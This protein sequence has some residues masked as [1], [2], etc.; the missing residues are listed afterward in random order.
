MGFSKNA[1]RYSW[2]VLMLLTLASAACALSSPEALN[3]GKGTRKN[4]IPPQ[5]YAHTPDYDVRA[6]GVV[7]EQPE[8]SQPVDSQD[9]QHL[10]V[11]FQIRCD[12]PEDAICQI[13]EIR[14]GIQLVD[15]SG[16][17]YDPVF[18]ATIENLL[19][20]E[21]LGDGEKAGWLAFQVP[22]GVELV[23]AVAEYGD[24]QHVFFQLPSDGGNR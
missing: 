13:E 7:W 22:R 17:L 10:R 6:L 19:E 12:K 8:H 14:Q 2:L 20:G 11:Q 1:R 5:T 21:I 24:D 9:T 3:D 18:S 16:I 23:S 4:P 15:A